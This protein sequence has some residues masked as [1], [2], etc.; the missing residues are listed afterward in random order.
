MSK[1]ADLQAYRIRVL[2]R[3]LDVGYLTREEFLPRNPRTGP[4][5]R[6]RTRQL[7]LLNRVF[8]ELSS[9]RVIRKGRISDSK[10]V[11]VY[12]VGIWRPKIWWR[13][14]PVEDIK[15]LAKERR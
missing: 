15:T 14:M 1:A 6:Q 9:E 3:L 10:H 13:Y 8:A 7:T 2:E 5:S 4:A 12:E 11:G